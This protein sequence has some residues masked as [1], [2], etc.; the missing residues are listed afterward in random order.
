MYGREVTSTGN[1]NKVAGYTATDQD[2]QLAEG[3]QSSDPAERTRL[4]G[5]H[6]HVRMYGHDGTVERRLEAA[7]FD[8]SVMAFAQELGDA[9]ARRHRLDPREELYVATRPLA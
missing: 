2:P 7:G 9:V 3:K 5:Q 6:D 4:F 1:H 8:V